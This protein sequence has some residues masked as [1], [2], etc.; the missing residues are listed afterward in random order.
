MGTAGPQLPAP[1]P[2]G[3]R[4]TQ[5]PSPG[6]SGHCWTSTRDL[7]S[8][9]RTAGPQPTLTGYCQNYIS[10][11]TTEAEKGGHIYEES[12]KSN[13]FAIHTERVNDRMPCKRFMRSPPAHPGAS[14]LHHQIWASQPHHQILASPHVKGLPSPISSSGLPSP[15]TSFGFYFQIWVPNDIYLL[16][17]GL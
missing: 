10:A 1:D 17:G 6:I 7:L 13:H 11:L 3:R 9:V 4:R 5:Q 8:P 16:L 12:G 15:I 14:G 2:S